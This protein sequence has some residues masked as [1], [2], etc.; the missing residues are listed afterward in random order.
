MDLRSLT[1]GLSLLLAVLAFGPARATDIYTF[2][3][4][5]RGSEENEAKVYKPVADYLTSATGKKIIYQHPDNWL[6]YQG[7]M[8]K[9][10]YDIVFD[11]PHFVSW[12]MAR[13]QH[14]PLVKLPGELGFVVAVKRG[15]DR[16]NSLKDL[17]GRT[18][19]G[20]APP[21][22]ATLTMYSQFDNPARQ[23]LVVEV[24]SF[25]DGYQELV[26]GE[27]CVAAVMRDKLY[28]KLDKDKQELKIIW[29]SNGVA[30]QAFSVGNRISVEDKEKITKALL[31]PG[32]KT[33]IAKFLER[34]NKGKDLIKANRPEYEGLAVLLKDVWGFEL[35]RNETKP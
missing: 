15:N 28:N 23:P 8:Q 29:N 14:E 24:K 16:L 21:N 34:F 9:G 13:L 27:K 33:N 11:G 1:A 3:A 30:N 6:S 18:V 22:L 32:A 26:K 19:C 12:R 2:T 4:P 35:A 31:A 20:L 25:K 7:Y 10:A 17:G 5:P